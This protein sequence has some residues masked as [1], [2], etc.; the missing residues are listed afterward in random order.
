MLLDILFAI[1]L[2]LIMVIASGAAVGVFEKIVHELK[3]NKLL[4][5]TILVG[6]STS[7]PELFVGIA[8]AMRGQP[9][10]A[11]G[12]ILGA[13][14]A[15]LSW[16]VGGTALVSGSIPIIGDFLRR[17]LWVTMGMGLLPLLLI[18]DGKLER[19]DGL[20]LIL[21]YLFYV[22]DM[23]RGNS[24]VLKHSK[25]ATQKKVKHHF[26][27]EVE[28]VL[29]IVKLI[30]SFGVLIVSSS[31][32]INLSIKMS[33]SFGVSVFWVGLLVISFGTTLPELVLSLMAT[34]KRE[35]SLVLGNILGSVVVNSTL[36][37]GIIVM[38]SPL[39]YSGTAQGSV[40][41]IFLV[42]VMGL[43]WMFTKSKHKLEKWEGMVLVGIYAMF[44]GIQFLLA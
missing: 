34:E 14:I 9:E 16:I 27:T 40:S 4:M 32:L 25:F 17:D 28:Y 10:I 37:L 39:K 5:A 30:A 11:L 38:I 22:R 6:F 21:V 8:S 42:A 33:S 13:N 35:I 31:A 41:G 43:F 18:S 7:L 20:V 36:I 15:N 19:L 23:L 12:N 26:K 24:M 2:I 3:V 29:E 44:V 1:I